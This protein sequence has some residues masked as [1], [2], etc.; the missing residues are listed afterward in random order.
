MRIAVQRA[1]VALRVQAVLL[2]L[3]AVK[4]GDRL[5]MEQQLLLLEW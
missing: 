5:L 2:L 3:T 1:E 4:R